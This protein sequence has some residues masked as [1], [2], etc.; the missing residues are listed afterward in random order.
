MRQVVVFGDRSCS[1]H[2]FVLQ[3]TSVYLEALIIWVEKIK[4]LELVHHASPGRHL[5][6]GQYYLKVVELAVL[7]AQGVVMIE[8]KWGKKIA[9]RN[10][11]GEDKSSG[12]DI[13][14][15]RYL[16]DQR[17]KLEYISKDAGVLST[18]PVSTQQS[19]NSLERGLPPSKL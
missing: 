17:L 13:T 7:T 9:D 11:V 10:V 1:C 19:R 5:P 2:S 3:A 14:R 15:W 8:L 18:L 4:K 6:W 16:N 12:A